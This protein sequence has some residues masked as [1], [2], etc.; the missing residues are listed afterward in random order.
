M[1]EAKCPRKIKYVQDD[2]AHRG[3]GRH[4]ILPVLDKLPGEESRREHGKKVQ[5]QHEGGSAE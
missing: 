5:L 1:I 2:Y 4:V 3:G